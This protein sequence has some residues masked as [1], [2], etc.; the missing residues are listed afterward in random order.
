MATIGGGLNSFLE[1]FE[2][3][4]K[5]VPKLALYRLWLGES[6]TSMKFLSRAG[7]DGI[8]GQLHDSYF[9]AEGGKSELDAVFAKLE[10]NYGK[11]VFGKKGVKL[12]PI[13]DLPLPTK[14]AEA[15]QNLPRDGKLKG[16]NP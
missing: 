10:K 15:L 5:E 12:E 9:L 1:N 11:P 2:G 6:I 13:P 14:M 4:D 3:K 16:G 7:G 8:W